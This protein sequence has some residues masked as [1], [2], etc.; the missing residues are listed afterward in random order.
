MPEGIPTLTETALGAF[1]HDIGKFAQRAG[2]FREFSQPSERLK[3]DILP[4]WKGSFSHWHALHT[5]EFFEWMEREGL[6]FPGPLRAAQVARVAVYHHKPGNDAFQWICAEA[7]RLSSGMERSERETE[8]EGVTPAGADAYRKTPMESA[9]ARV[10]ILESRGVPELSY[11][12]LGA[13]AA[14]RGAVPLKKPDLESYPAQYE[15]LWREFCGEFRKICERKGEEIFCQALQSLS[16]RYMHAV[17]ASTVDQPDISLHD[18][19]RASA[20]IAAAMYAWHEAD[21]TL[22]SVERVRDRGLRKFRFLSGELSGI[23]KSLFQLAHQ[24]VSGASRILR[25]RSFLMGMVVEGAALEARRIFGLPVF[26]VL[27]SAGGRFLLLAPAT[28]D[29]EEKVEELRRRIEP[30]L[31]ARWH[32][33]LALS[34]ALSE[35]FAGKDLMQGGYRR[36]SAELGRAAEEA[37]QRVF[38]MCLQEPVHRGVRYDTGWVCSAC[39]VRPGE[40]RQQDGRTVYRCDACEAERMAGGVLPKARF[41]S[42][43]EGEGEGDGYRFRMWKGLSFCLSEEAPHETASLLAA[44]RIGGAGGMEAAGWAVRQTA[45]HVP[46]VTEQDL[47]KKSYELLGEEAREQRPGDAKL[48]EHIALDSVK[49]E[50]DGLRGTPLLGV[51]KADV[52]YLGAIFHQGL[53]E[54]ASLSRVAGLSRMM[55]YFFSAQLKWLVEER[56]PSMYTVYAGGDD[57]LMIGPWRQAL[58]FAAAMRRE[59]EQWTGGN[60]QITISAGIEIVKPGEPLNR[61]A[62][63]A[64]ERLER[65]KEAGRNRV[66]ALDPA[67]L[68]WEEFEELL[69]EGTKLEQLLAAKELPQALLYRF[70]ELDEARV[71]VEQIRGGRSAVDERQ[72]AW[73]ARWAYQAGRNLKKPEQAEVRNLLNSLLGLDR[74]FRKRDPKP[75]SRTAVTIAVLANRKPTMEWREQA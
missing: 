57:L 3:A 5:A 40:G 48:F 6:S 70:L 19:A 18:H 71:A 7:D 2:A 43:R 20:A 24:Q 26:S 47:E 32:G 42:W 38:Q 73:R 64:E 74:E 56:F 8:R 60:P 44:E 15:R 62:E 27:Q 53:G 17:P 21:G 50:G 14:G 29:A 34:L 55:D 39:G 4:S 13:L 54:R 49:E 23:Q 10:K 35:P 61:A 72:A 58:E 59:F 67:A 12:P 63:R 45:H 9:F 16:E 31:Y 68:K 30:W 1:L 11:M 52:D 51:V 28:A 46:R 41:V 75:P 33:R 69:A 25:A 37:R 36:L 65:A 22:E 66:C